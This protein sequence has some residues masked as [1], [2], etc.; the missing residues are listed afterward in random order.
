MRTMT[1]KI[2]ALAVVCAIIAL[3]A[4]RREEAC[5]QPMKLGGPIAEQPVH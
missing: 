2:A 4:S 5:C 3:G 1:K